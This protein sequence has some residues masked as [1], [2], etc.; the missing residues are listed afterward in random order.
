MILVGSTSPNYHLDVSLIPR[1][2]LKHSHSII[3]GNCF[4]LFWFTFFLHTQPSCPEQILL[5]KSQHCGILL[6]KDRF[7][8]ETRT[9]AIEKVLY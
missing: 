9:F 3:F 8:F 7:C 1:Y 5:R 4:G 6:E 2:R